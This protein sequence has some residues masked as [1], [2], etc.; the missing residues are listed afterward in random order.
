MECHDGDDTRERKRKRM[1]EGEHRVDHEMEDGGEDVRKE[2]EN[3]EIK[4]N[5]S[6]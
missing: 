6:V 1:M 2:G 4:T 5:S 3:E